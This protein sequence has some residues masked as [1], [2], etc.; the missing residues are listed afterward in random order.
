MLFRSR[1]PPLRTI[2]RADFETFMSSADSVWDCYAF[3]CHDNPGYRKIDWDKFTDAGYRRLTATQRALNNINLMD[4]Q[5]CNGGLVQL[6]FNYH[7]AIEEVV[8]AVNTL[9]WSELTGRFEDKYAEAFIRP[10]N[11]GSFEGLNAEFQKKARK[12]PWKEAAKAFK[13]AVDEFDFEDF[14]DWYYED[15]TRA[16]L[17]RQI[18]RMMRERADDLFEVMN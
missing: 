18:K 3:A 11:A 15:E 12:R 16:E 2:A 17:V 6:F 4:G 14:D 10:G 9:E 1:K 5:I 13:A 7:D 8:T